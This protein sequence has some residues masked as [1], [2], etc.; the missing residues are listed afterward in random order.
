MRRAWSFILVVPIVLLAAG[1]AS[2]G[3]EA[4]I[5]VA[6]HAW[7][8]DLSGDGASGK[9]S[10]NAFDLGNDL[11][12]DGRDVYPSLDFL[13][14]LGRHRIVLGYSH[15]SVD[16]DRLRSSVDLNR[17][18]VF[19]GFSFIN[20]NVLDVTALIGSDGYKLKTKASGST[21]A[22]LDSSAPAIGLSVGI[23][24]PAL[25]LRFYGEIVRSSWK[26]SGVDT[27]LTDAYVAVDWYLIPVFKIFGLQA[28][29]RS[30]SLNAEDTGSGEKSDYKYH[31]PFAGL[32]FRF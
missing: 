1:A 17:Q 4:H 15:G 26:V 13:A 30:Y 11:G 5:Y 31:G 8:A 27:K 2:R 32:V 9:G 21:L 6:P 3:E 20:L 12:A 10:A 28:G 14:R 23:R 7:F 24:P 16:G 22:D 18:R 19:Y 25:P 29:Y